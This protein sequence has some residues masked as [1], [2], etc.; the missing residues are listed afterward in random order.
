MKTRSQGVLGVTLVSFACSALSACGVDA[1]AGLCEAHLRERL[2][3]PETL[4]FKDFAPASE[5]QAKALFAEMYGE[6]LGEDA[7]RFVSLESFLKQFRATKPNSE[8]F[9]AR[10]RAEGR[11]GNTI[12]EQNVCLVDAK[13][14]ECVGRS[15]L[16]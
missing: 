7:F 12:T 6:V 3:N 15:L 2:L 13:S 11:L 14:C 9:T 5:A 10:V 8:M 16:S 1:R 4:E